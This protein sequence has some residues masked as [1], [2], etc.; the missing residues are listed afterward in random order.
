VVAKLSPLGPAFT[1]PRK[2]A[3]I[4]YCE[5][6]PVH[7]RLDMAL[8]VR[9]AAQYI[10]MSTDTQDL[11]PMV[12]KEAIAA[13]AASHALAVVASYEDEGRSGVYITNRPGLSKLL[14]D[15][16]SSPPFS[17]VL[18]YD[19]SRWGR[20]Q[21]ADASAYYDYHCRLHKVQVVYVAES[22]GTDITPMG[23]LAKNMKRVMAAEYSRE[24]AGKCRAGQHRVVNMGYQMG[25]LPPLGYR[26][27]S[28]SADRQRKVILEHGQRKLALTDRIEWILALRTSWP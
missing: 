16:T 15:V 17:V 25:Q 5:I 22:F 28:V 3:R 8:Q 4:D 19:V 23:T 1:M 13:Y 14:R 9:A 24:L 12:Q 21:D 7:R 18:V 10:R 27:C 20:F 26:R 11:S 6:H 2:S